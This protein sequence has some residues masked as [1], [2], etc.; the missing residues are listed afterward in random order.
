MSQRLP[1]QIRTVFIRQGI[2]G[3]ALLLLALLSLAVLFGEFR[4]RQE[5]TAVAKQA[6]R[7]HADNPRVQTYQFGNAAVFLA[8]SSQTAEQRY[9]GF[10]Q[11]TRLQP[12][13]QQR[14]DEQLRP[15]TTPG[16]DI[17]WR[18]LRLQLN[19]LDVY[20]VRDTHIANR[21]MAWFLATVA[22][23]TILAFGLVTWQSYLAVKR[24]MTPIRELSD[25]VN[26]WR[27]GRLDDSALRAMEPQ[28]SASVEARNLWQAMY[29]LA[30]R[31][32]AFTLRENQFLRDA[33]HELRTPL[34]VIDMSVDSLETQLSDL[35]ASRRILQRLRQAS[36]R[37]QSKL[38]ALMLLTRE[39]EVR[40]LAEPFEVR[41]L[42]EQQMTLV[43]TRFADRDVKLILEPGSPV[44]VNGTAQAFA[45]IME[46]LLANAMR[47]T[48]QGLVR[49]EVTPECVSVQD[50]GSGM[51]DEALSR[52]FDPLF[53]EDP[54]AAEGQGIGLTLVSQLA[55]R[56]GWHVVLHSEPGNGTRAELRFSP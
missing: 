11:G 31:I 40:M 35:P 9:A 22:L 41:E 39:N 21:N 23:A 43:R 4:M 12:G 46:Q 51:S 53:R 8:A 25:A 44:I 14:M 27:P 28:A 33:G 1:S 56:A 10:L 50:S 19:G 34:T 37:I 7:Q 55:E 6:V 26:A 17:N 48:A 3:C 45:L 20:L 5:L 36:G 30:Q 24:V 18:H 47:F 52:A 2:F 54:F 42:A 49:V 32:R 13:F 16:L 15:N 38:D 29:G